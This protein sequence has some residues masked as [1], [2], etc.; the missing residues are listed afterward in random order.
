MRRRRG[1]RQNTATMPTDSGGESRR[2]GVLSGSGKRG[3]M[4]RRRRRAIY[5]RESVVELGREWWELKRDKFAHGL[6]HRRDFRPRLKTTD[7]W[8]PLLVRVREKRG[9]D[10]GFSCWAVGW[11]I[12]WAEGVPRALLYF[13][14]LFFTFLFLFSYFFYN[15]WFCYSN[16]IKPIA[17]TF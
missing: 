4:E 10:S 16:D 6:G 13:F 17:E 2:S 12:C 15:F 3:E 5:R 1:N 8:G 11:F 9:T 14:F 7:G